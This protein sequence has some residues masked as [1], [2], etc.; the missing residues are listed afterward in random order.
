MTIS[1]IDELVSFILNSDATDPGTKWGYKKH[2]ESIYTGE[3]TK[4]S[5]TCGLIYNNFPN[6]QNRPIFRWHTYGVLNNQSNKN[7]R[8]YEKSRYIDFEAWIYSA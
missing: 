3:P 5:S 7:I 2:L 4:S 6:V 1:N 8:Q